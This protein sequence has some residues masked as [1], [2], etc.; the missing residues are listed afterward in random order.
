MGGFKLDIID[1]ADKI[2]IMFPSLITQEMMT[3]FQG[4]QNNCFKVTSFSLMLEGSV[5]PTKNYEN[6]LPV[7]RIKMASININNPNLALNFQIML[8]YKRA[9]I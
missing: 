3:D 5:F 7:D 9:I 4:C 2:L 6:E 8:R 1:E